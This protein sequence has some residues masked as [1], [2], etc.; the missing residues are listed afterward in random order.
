[1]DGFLANSLQPPQGQLISAWKAFRGNTMTHTP[2]ELVQRLVALTSSEPSMEYFVS[3]DYSNATDTLNRDASLASLQGVLPLL[4][5]H[6][7]SALSFRPAVLEYP[8]TAGGKF[9]YE[10]KG[11]KNGK[12]I[13]VRATEHLTQ[14]GGQAMGHPLSFPLLCSINLACLRHAVSIWRKAEVQE[15]KRLRTT[16]IDNLFREHPEWKFRDGREVTVVPQVDASPRKASPLKQLIQKIK[17]LFWQHILHIHKIAN[18]ILSTSIVNGDDL[19]FKCPQGFYPIWVACI[20]DAG[21]VLS[22]GKNYVSR[23]VCQV[24][25]EIFKVDTTGVEKIGYLNQKLIFGDLN[26]ESVHAQE[27]WDKNTHSMRKMTPV[28]LASEL[29]TMFRYCE[30]APRAL[31]LAFRR[32]D[33]DFSVTK[34]HGRR[35]NWFLPP[36]L[37]GFGVEPKYA[38]KTPEYTKEQLTMATWMVLNPTQALYRVIQPTKRDGLIDRYFAGKTA[39]WKLLRNLDQDLKHAPP[40]L[41]FPRDSIEDEW[42]QRLTY[43]SRIYDLPGALTPNS[44]DWY[45]GSGFD[46]QPEERLASAPLF[47][48]KWPGRSVLYS[49]EG[50]D[51]EI[52]R[53]DALLFKNKLIGSGQGIPK[54]RIELSKKVQKPNLYGIRPMKER[55]VVRWA[56]A[57]FMSGALPACPPLRPLVEVTQGFQ[58]YATYNALRK[59]YLKGLRDGFSAEDM[60]FVNVMDQTEAR[61]NQNAK[62]LHGSPPEEGPG[63]PDPSS[64]PTAIS[65]DEGSESDLDDFQ[66]TGR[67]EF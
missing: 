34:L 9:V 31:G 65:W 29:N 51:G 17:E 16:T 27:I 5:D 60:G 41:P 26:S 45:P 43:L 63:T 52:P 6:A 12:P 47:R 8:Q 40:S 49:Q 50:W 10:T 54:A 55:D 7:I 35:P 58:N 42:F 13:L 15:V 61:A 21:F 62:R 19:L 66:I 53:S 64:Q 48:K 3:A 56:H 37:G 44:E 14:R 36:H 4:A 1:M 28:T 20:Q 33:G 24:N 23:T 30:F 25:S 57:S 2:T 39:D 32:W 46:P 67:R 22:T 11:M 18:L 59:R 38:W